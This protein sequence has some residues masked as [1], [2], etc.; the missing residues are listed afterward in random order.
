MFTLYMKI[1]FRYMFYKNFYIEIFLP[2]YM[3]EKEREDGDGGGSPIFQGQFS[4]GIG[5]KWEWIKEIIGGLAFALLMAELYFLLWIFAP[6]GA[7]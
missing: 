4:I 2:Y 1:G 6:E 5:W 7:W 3:F